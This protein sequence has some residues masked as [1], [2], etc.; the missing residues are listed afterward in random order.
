MY[1]IREFTAFSSSFLVTSSQ[2][3]SGPGHFGHLRLRD[4]NSC[5]VTTS[6][7]ELQD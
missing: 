2:M 7:C 5:H 4:V 3:T 6:P 1:S